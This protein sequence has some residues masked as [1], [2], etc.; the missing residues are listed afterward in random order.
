MP[1][2]PDVQAP[3]RYA[4]AKRQQFLI[5]ASLAGAVIAG[6]VLLY[7]GGAILATMKSPPSRPNPS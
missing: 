3:E 5:V 1:E 6:A 7:I 4:L 2:N